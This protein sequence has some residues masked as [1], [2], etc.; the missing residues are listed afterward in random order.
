MAELTPDE[1]QVAFHDVECTTYDERFGIVF[2]GFAVDAVDREVTRLLGDHD[3]GRVLDVGCG[4]GYLAIG[5]AAN[6]RAG[7]VHA[8]DISSG[9]LERARDNA[10]GADADVCFVRGSATSLPYADDSFEA[11]VS[12]GVLHHLHDPVAALR[13]WRR[14][15]R[16]G[17]PV[18]VLSEPTPLADVVGGASA[19]A[20]A[21][22]LAAGRRVAERLGRPLPAH[23]PDTGEEHRFWDLVA[24]AANLHT[25]APARLAALSREA[26]F[27][28]VDVRGAGLVSIVWAA[29]YYHLVGELPP[30]A[31]SA[32]AKRLAA[33][34][35]TL[36]RRLDATVF[37][38]LLPDRALLT[39]Q[40]VLST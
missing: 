26:G 14:V 25:F 40:A 15:A 3:V 13:E 23:D 1:L 31:D 12:R 9:M 20:A 4:T 34:M 24:M 35:W 2:D 39:V 19:R 37:D 18:V 10:R 11:V 6:R 29:A 21:T 36:T 5:L 17:A 22:V 7:R 8:I 27:A 38:R 16:D 32:R 33:R 30:L 28:R